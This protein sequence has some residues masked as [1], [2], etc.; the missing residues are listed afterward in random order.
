[1]ERSIKVDNFSSPF[2]GADPLQHRICFVCKLDPAKNRFVVRFPYTYAEY[3]YNHTNKEL[4]GEKLL[5]MC[6][7]CI[8][9]AASVAGALPAPEA[10]NLRARLFSAEAARAR[11][12]KRADSAEKALFAVQDMVGGM[13][14]DAK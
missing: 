5:E 3:L 6:A 7:D 2:P 8:D 9:E 12:E 10:E 11:A 4:V 1:M 14:A 13:K